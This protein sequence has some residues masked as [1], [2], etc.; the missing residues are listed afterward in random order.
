M[1]ISS[2]TTGLLAA[3]VDPIKVTGYTSILTPFLMPNIMNIVKVDSI[4]G[5]CK[6]TFM[7]IVAAICSIIAVGTLS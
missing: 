4:L 1:L 5:V 6:T 3:K 2:I 7:G